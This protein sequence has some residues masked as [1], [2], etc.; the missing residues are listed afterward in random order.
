MSLPLGNHNGCLYQKMKRNLCRGI[1]IRP[2]L[3]FKHTAGNPVFGGSVVLIAEIARLNEF[4]H[5]T[6]LRDIQRKK[7]FFIEPGPGNQPGTIKT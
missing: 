6:P 3:L 2:N 4:V 7:I 5:Y 1:Y